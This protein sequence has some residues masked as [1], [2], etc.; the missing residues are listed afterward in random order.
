MGHDLCAQAIVDE[1]WDNAV[2]LD[3]QMNEVNEW[4]LFAE[5]DADGDENPPPDVT[6]ACPQFDTVTVLYHKITTKGLI[7]IAG[8]VGITQS[9]S[10]RKVFDGLRY[11]E[12]DV[13][14][15]DDS[16][17]YRYEIVKGEE[18]SMWVILALEPSRMQTSC[19][20]TNRRSTGCP[21]EA[22]SLGPHW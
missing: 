14:I 6:N 7:K 19:C 5:D 15:D 13:K 12:Y 3:V 2:F 9:G 10:K 4:E 8:K 17:E 18:V 1:L 21:I 11:L 22:R 16:F 20:N